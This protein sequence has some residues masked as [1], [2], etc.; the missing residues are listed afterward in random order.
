MALE[1][2]PRLYNDLAAWW[3]LFSPPS[4]YVEEAADLLPVLLTAT[5]SPH[6]LLELGS[7]GGSLA[8]HLKSCFLLTLTDRSPAMLEVSRAVNPEC[9]HIIGDMR[10]LA[11]GREFDL[12]LIHDAIMYATDATSLRATLRT[13]YRHCRRGGAVVILP[14]CV[15]ETF[16]PTTS[17]GGDDAADGRGP[18]YLEWTWDPDP[19]DNTFDVAYAFLLRERD[20]SLH[21][22]IDRHR[23]GLFAR[24]DWF[25][26]LREVGFSATS[27]IDPWRRDVFVGRKA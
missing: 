7:G 12:V 16:E 21:V 24:A 25:N 17:S 20:G 10:S 9:E 1:Q 4:E 2:E 15:K 18:R 27:H 13:A 14:D 26:W 23:C 5:E 3:P 11:L 6:S 19:N 22:D 8:N